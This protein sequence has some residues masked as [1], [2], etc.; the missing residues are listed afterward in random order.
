MSFL[1]HHLFF[2]LCRHA[3]QKG[4]E[5]I[6][7]YFVGDSI[8][9]YN[10]RRIIRRLKLADYVDPITG[11]KEFEGMR[12]PYAYANMLV[13]TLDMDIEPSGKANL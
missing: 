13:I 12:S 6:L 4:I 3:K 10:N 9:L 11:R 7:V 8:N 1:K 2:R 5:K